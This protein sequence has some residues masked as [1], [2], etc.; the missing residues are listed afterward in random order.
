MSY[1]TVATQFVDRDYRLLRGLFESRVMTVQ[2]AAA[3][4]FGGSLEAARKR[5]WKLKNAALVNSAPV[6]DRMTRRSC[7]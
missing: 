1:T 6:R 5:V 4:Y 7:I 3:L 2:H